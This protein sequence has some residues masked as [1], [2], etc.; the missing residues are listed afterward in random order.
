MSGDAVP[1]RYFVAAFPDEAS[2]EAVVNARLDIA[3]Q[4]PDSSVRFGRVEYMHSTLVYLGIIDDD[5]AVH[6]M[7]NVGEVLNAWD[8]DSP[9]LSRPVEVSGL[10]IFGRGD[11]VGLVLKGDPIQQLYGLRNAVVAAME[12]KGLPHDEREWL[13]HLSIMRSRKART[14]ALDEKGEFPFTFDVQS[15]LPTIAFERFA[16]VRSTSTPPNGPHHDHFH[17]RWINL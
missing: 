2:R 16:L 10:R 11:V 14:I 5:T 15:Q 13:P 3:A 9:M 6:V 17:T 12:S 1:K 4:L 7:E 8:F